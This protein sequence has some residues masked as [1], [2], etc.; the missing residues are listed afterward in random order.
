MSLNLEDDCMCY[1]CGKKNP[2]GLRLDFEHPEK[3]KLKASVIFSKHHQGYKNIVHGGLIATVLDEMMVNL[4]W[5]EGV[6]AVTVEL[7]I[8][9]KKAIPVDQKVL[10]EGQLDSV[11]EGKNRLIQA[12]ATAKDEKGVLLASGTATCLRIKSKLD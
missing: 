1:V 12:S 6:P 5:K 2:Q 10:L 11:G 3:N 9:L 4:A 8:R 7:N